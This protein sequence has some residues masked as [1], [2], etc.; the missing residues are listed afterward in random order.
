MP[1]S[2]RFGPA[3]LTAD[4]HTL[5]ALSSSSFAEGGGRGACARWDTFAHLIPAIPGSAFHSFR[6]LP[7][8]GQAEDQ[9]GW[10][11]VS[12]A[13]ASSP[14]VLPSNRQLGRGRDED[15]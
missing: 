12:T 2:P 8:Q 14:H 11:P 7:T 9:G 10:M 4:S 15:K 5:A 1:L 6:Q 3:Y 13:A